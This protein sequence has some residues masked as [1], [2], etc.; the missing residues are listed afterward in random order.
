MPFLSKLGGFAIHPV[1]I[2]QDAQDYIDLNSS[3]LNTQLSD[4]RMLAQVIN[5]GF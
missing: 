5:E 4:R 2:T 1:H 3:L